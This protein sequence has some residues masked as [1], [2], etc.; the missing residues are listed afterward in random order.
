MNPTRTLLQGILLL[1]GFFV[2][3]YAFSHVKFTKLFRINTIR[4]STEQQI[5]ELIWNQIEREEDVIYD[6]SLTATLDR[7]ILPICKANGIERD[8]LKVHL[9]RKDELNAFALPAGHL[10]V[11]T[12]LIAECEKQEALQGVLGHEIAHIERNHVMRKLSKEIGLSVLLSIASGGK[13]SQVRDL[14]AFLSST[15]YDRS[16]EEEADMESVRYLMK[17]RINPEP[18]A[19]FMYVMAEKQNLPEGLEWVSTHPES[20]SRAKMILRYIKGKRKG[21]KQTLTSAEWEA[22]KSAAPGK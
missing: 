3:F 16:L 15:A 17:A 13:A 6:D 14:I 20:E 21:M 22:F 4:T 19:D 11:Y 5:G 2:M 10:A 9:I 12:G 18:M 7:I 1:A 8:S